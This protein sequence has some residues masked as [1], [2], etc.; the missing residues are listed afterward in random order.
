MAKDVGTNVSY[1]I[2]NG[3]D[4]IPAENDSQG[5]VC[6][7]DTPYSYELFQH[8]S[9]TQQILMALLWLCVIL[10]VAN[11]LE[12]LVFIIRHFQISVRIQKTIY[13]LALMP[14]YALC[15]IIGVMV[16]RAGILIDLVSNSYFGFAMYNWMSLIDDY[17][18]PEGRSQARGVTVLSLATPPICCFCVCLPK[19]TFNKKTYLRLLVM[20]Y[21]V[22]VIRPLLSFIA[23]VL[24][25]DGQYVPGTLG[26]NAFTYVSCLN[27]VST[28]FAVWGLIIVQKAF[29]KTLKQFLIFVKFVV[30]QLT[31][32]GTVL[33]N[34]IIT[35][36]VS[37][38]IIR[39]TELISTGA[40]AARMDNGCLVIW[41]LCLSILGR[42]AF[43]RK[44][45]GL[46][47]RQPVAE[48]AALKDKDNSVE[49][50]DGTFHTD[51]NEA[52]ITAE[53]QRKY[54]NH[55]V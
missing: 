18:G 2:V 25:A 6:R 47:Q 8:Q 32:I 48:C 49:P 55:N 14:V 52:A 33:F 7:E 22:T 36:L 10:I 28:L 9:T 20:V 23:A 51:I 26:N 38:G 3:S 12:E 17:L 19:F 34:V 39:C 41:M 21:Q 45:D 54:L 15:A 11:F 24:W 40:R 44:Q 50:H 35:V 4:V 29:R 13:I 31:L 27:T 5:I 30:L 42:I 37:K 46:L 16:P 1:I 53:G 43:R